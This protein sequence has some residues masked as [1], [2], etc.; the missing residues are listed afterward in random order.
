MASGLPRFGGSEQRGLRIGGGAAGAVKF[1]AFTREAFPVEGGFREEVESVGCKPEFILRDDT[2][3]LAAHGVG[4]F[5]AW[6]A[7][8]A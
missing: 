2:A 1:L 4:S 5:Q 7:S 8:A 3:F 6:F